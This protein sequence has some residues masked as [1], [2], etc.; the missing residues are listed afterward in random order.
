MMHNHDQETI[1]AL[2]EGLLPPAAAAAAEAEISACVECVIDLEL[3]RIALA[4]LAKAPPAYLSATESARLHDRLHMKLAVSPAEPVRTR[5]QLAWGRWVGL[6]A[7]A[8]AMFLAVFMVLPNVLGGEDDDSAESVAFDQVNE[9]LVDAATETT[10]ASIEAAPP[11][12]GERLG[13]DMAADAEDGAASMTEVPAATTAAPETTAGPGLAYSD[14][15]TMGTLTEELRLEIV[16]QLLADP[17]AFR[18]RGETLKTVEPE[19]RACLPALFGFDNNGD[20]DPLIPTI[21]GTI[22]DDLGQE[23]LLVALVPSDP[24]ATMLVSITVPECTIFETLP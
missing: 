4:T 19:W 15:I 24:A 18:T 1:M 17:E 13:G 6:A 11:M 16:D 14:Y 5:S 20:P 12:D 9:G 8:A 7:G 2:A 3:Q 10:T 21:V 22:V 23:R